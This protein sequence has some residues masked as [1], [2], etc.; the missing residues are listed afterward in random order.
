MCRTVGGVEPLEGGVD[1]GKQVHA[2]A[3][4]GWPL[5]CPFLFTNTHEYRHVPL[6]MIANKNR[7]ECLIISR[8]VGGV[9]PLERGV[10]HQC[11]RPGADGMALRRSYSRIQMIIGICLYSL[12][13][14]RTRVPCAVPLAVYSRWRAVST[15]ARSVHAPALTGWPSVLS[16]TPVAHV[17]SS[18]SNARSRPLDTWRHHQH[19]HHRHRRR[20]RHRD[21]PRMILINDIIRSS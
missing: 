15:I 21:G 2:P 6:L 13:Q 4:T 16:A 19:H 8:T 9:E 3:R 5:A 14:T 10:D 12:S 17:L 7:N 11:A 1:H 20:Q 18:A